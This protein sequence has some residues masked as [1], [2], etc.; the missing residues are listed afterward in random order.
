MRKSVILEGA[1]GCGKSTLARQLEKDLG[2]TYSHSGPNPG[3]SDK[4]REACINQIKLLEQGC[5]VDRVTPIS[6][7]IYDWDVI[8]ESELKE[9]NYFLEVML[10]RA[11]V[12]HCTATGLFTN[13]SYYPEGHYERVLKDSDKIKELY[14]DLMQGIP[15][16]KYDWTSDSYYKLLEKINES[17]RSI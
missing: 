14:A 17:L 15:H 8:P 2:L 3:D 1:N 4:A 10:S 9:Y 12:I 7:V 5:V 16:I 11:V 6:R 13:K